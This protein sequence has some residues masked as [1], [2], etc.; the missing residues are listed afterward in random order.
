[1]SA[2][3]VAGVQKGHAGL[4]WQRSGSTAAAPSGNL[5]SESNPQEKPAHPQA[6]TQESWSHARQ[7]NG[8]I[9]AR[10]QP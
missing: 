4:S 7:P 9:R 3:C 5:S 2:V 6:V 1:M 10:H 8:R